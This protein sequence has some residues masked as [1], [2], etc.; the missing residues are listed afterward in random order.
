MHPLALTLLDGQLMRQDVA[1]GAE[2]LAQHFT[3]RQ[4]A[5]TALQRGGTEGT[6]HPASHLGGDAK[7]IAVVVVHQHALNAVAVLHAKE[8]LHR[9]VD[10]RAALMDDLHRLGDG[11]RLQLLAQG[12][13]QIGHGVEIGPLVNPLEYLPG[14]EGR[15]LARLAP[16]GQFSLAQPSQLGH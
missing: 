3:R 14:T 4:R 7:R 1:V 10:F 2:H 15:K 9:I 11:L 6:A 8:E 13:G 12:Q 16:I 5:H